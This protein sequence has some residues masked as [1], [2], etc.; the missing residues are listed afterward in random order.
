MYLSIYFI[1]FISSTD[2]GSPRKSCLNLRPYYTHL[3]A[4]TILDIFL[5]SSIAPYENI[6][7]FL[8]KE[9]QQQ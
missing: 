5:F 3:G 2:V 1:F 7:S 6:V 8:H 9:K 4:A